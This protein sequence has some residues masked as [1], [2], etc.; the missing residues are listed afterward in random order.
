MLEESGRGRHGTEDRGL[1]PTTHGWAGTLTVLEREREKER[2]KNAALAC[3]CEMKKGV[4]LAAKTQGKKVWQWF[5]SSK[6]YKSK[7]GN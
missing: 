4:W 5:G 2:R 6:K 1:S 7:E 3:Y